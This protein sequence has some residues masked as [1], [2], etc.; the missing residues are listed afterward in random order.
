MDHS[1]TVVTIGI[2]KQAI[3]FIS[4]Q[5]LVY[6]FSM[7]VSQDLYQTTGLSFPLLHLTIIFVWTVVLTQ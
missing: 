2:T 3:L 1:K 5:V 6:M 4:M 7:V